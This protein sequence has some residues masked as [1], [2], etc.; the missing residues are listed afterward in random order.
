MLEQIGVSSVE[1]LMESLAC[2]WEL[3][4]MKNIYLHYTRMILKCSVINTHKQY[5]LQEMRHSGITFSHSL[6]AY[7]DGAA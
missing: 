6:Q 4:S 1:Q 2:F 7:A 3:C 5:T